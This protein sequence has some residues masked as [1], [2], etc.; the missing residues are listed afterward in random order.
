MFILQRDGCKAVVDPSE[1]QLL[2]NLRSLKLYGRSQFLVLSTMDGDWIQIAGGT[3]SCIVE[4]Y[5]AETPVLWR[6]HRRLALSSFRDAT[7]FGFRGHDREVAP[8]EILRM[9]EA[10]EILL[11]FRSGSDVSALMSWRAI[12]FGENAASAVGFGEIKP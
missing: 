5:S 10:E 1:R 2:H 6:A 9:A 7:K 4:R 12:V 8:D 3:L 11:A